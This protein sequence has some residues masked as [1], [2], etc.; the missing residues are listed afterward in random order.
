MKRILFLFCFLAI[1]AAAFAD[2]YYF[3]SQPDISPDGQTVVFCY[4]GDIWKVAVTGGTA[5]RLTAMD[6]IES[7]PRI[8]TD[9]KWLAFSGQLDGNSNVYVMPL[10]GGAI[11]QLTYHDGSDQ[12]DSWGWDSET[13]YFTS[14]R[15]NSF[16]GYSVKRTG[17]TPARLVN[18]Y[19]NTIHGVV[20]NPT[21]GSIWFTDTWESYRFANRKGYKGEFN[22]DLKSYN[23]ETKEFTIHTT[24]EGKDFNPSFDESGRLYF[25]S[26]E[27]DPEGGV[28]NLYRLDKDRKAQ[29]TKFDQSVRNPRVS[30]G[31]SKVVFEKGYQLFTYDAGTGT[32]TPL[33]VT[34]FSDPSMKL[35]TS[36]DVKGKVEAF[37]V[38]PD[39]KKLAFVSRGE[40]FVSDIKG[41][42]VR[43]LDTRT[44]GRVAE[45]KWLKDSKRVVFSQTM[46]G[47]YNWFVIPADGTGEE[48]QLTDTETNNR[49]I[50]LNGDRTK[51]VYLSGKHH[52][53]VMD[54]DKLEARMIV[55]ENLW[56]F[57]NST[58]QFS[59]DDKWVVF[60]AYRNFEED[61]FLHN[62]E[63]GETFNIT[64]TGVSEGNPTFSSDGKYLYFSSDRI[65]PG[66]PRG[67]DETH[68]YRI[69]LQKF[70]EA[71]RADEFDKLFKEEKKDDKNGKEEEKNGKGEEKKPSVV[72]KINMD[73]FL[74]RFERI[75]PSR[76]TQ[77]GPVVLV[78]DETH[79]VIY[80][81]NHEDGERAL[82][83]TIIKPFEKPETKQI[84][85]SGNGRGGF[86]IVT[87][88]KK[89]YVLS[90]GRVHELNL[91]KSS[92]KAIDISY[93]FTRNMQAEFNQMFDEMWA[94]LYENYYDENFHGRDW[95]AVREKYRQYLPYL[96][97]RNDVKRLFNDMLGE[98][99]SSHQGFY[100]GGKEEKTFHNMK[101]I[102]AGIVFDRENPYRVREILKDS[103]LDKVDKDVKTGDMLV[104]VNG[105]D[106]Q[107]DANREQYF[108]FPDAPDEMTLTFKRG[109]ERIFTVRFHP[110]SSN[111][112]RNRF[113]D[114]W[115]DINQKRVDEKSNKRIA[116]IHMRNMG[117][118]EL[119][120]FFVEMAS[121]HY[122]RHALI[123]DLRNNTGG[124]VHDAVLN[125]LSRKLYA[126]WKYR[127]DS[128]M[129][130]QPNFYPAD[131][132][133]VLLI[134]EQTLSDG[135]MTAAG[136]KALNLGTV[137]GT[138]TYRW[139]IFTS[140]KGLV[141]ESYYRLPC[142]GCYTLDGTDIEMNGVAPDVD[143]PLTVKDKD[144]GD[145][146]QLD[147]A[148]EIIMGELGSQ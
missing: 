114:A 6:G 42:F 132:P 138:E 74:E 123:L 95:P 57:Y 20:V 33:K 16:T 21:D 121:E 58:P 118:G 115:E 116:Y 14:S 64:D 89:N 7:R 4:N 83:Q 69:A 68:I 96:T 129:S 32:A 44:D 142:W 101:T 45:V 62:L 54:M 37:D 91:G 147:K 36:H 103:P 85:K 43:Q 87:V 2:D 141:D 8:S 11:R 50:Y 84:K 29:L 31:G 56:G 94:S 1:S 102:A 10:A 13:I 134:N 17:G 135:E 125:L 140:G 139:L 66:Y 59:P 23:L 60:T 12:V 52:V 5:Y 119:N 111:S 46:N 47:W 48:K 145:D 79:T 40:L 55:Q 127:G 106:V 105:E 130:P 131:K 126:K 117:G 104:A 93:A 110:E 90:G 22:P 30:A 81:S 100:S 71:Y 88:D 38:A 51:A 76:G 78:D 133:I 97:N 128:S 65:N 39:G 41:R 25:I 122:Q 112:Y 99:N 92:L 146:P 137:V 24:W 148:I 49:G 35:E 18:G 27:A 120:K 67:A 143:V 75:S 107:S 144:L 3:L 109:E 9:G 113:Y 86:E 34:L 26:D 72:V 70:D 124:N 63:K 28:T 19:F 98:L 80:S 77:S 61:I 15:E 82:Y 108:R 136:F 73:R 53:M